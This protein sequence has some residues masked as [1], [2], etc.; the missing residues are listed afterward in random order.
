ML[1][2]WIYTREKVLWNFGWQ[3]FFCSFFY[4]V[5]FCNFL[6]SLLMW[7]GNEAQLCLYY[8]CLFNIIWACIYSGVFFTLFQI[9]VFSLYIPFIRKGRS[10][11]FSIWKYIILPLTKLSHCFM[12]LWTI[13]FCF[14][15][16][17]CTIVHNNCVYKTFYVY[18]SREK[19]DWGVN[20]VG[21]MRRDVKNVMIFY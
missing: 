8:V 21:N 17:H 1:L 9:H 10:I 11:T 16:T 2:G 7:N 12:C 20:M 19:K 15:S 6:K 18:L 4:T 14:F 13:F 3:F 5:L